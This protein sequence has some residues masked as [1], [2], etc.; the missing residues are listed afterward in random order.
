MTQFFSKLPQTFDLQSIGAEISTKHSNEWA[1]SNYKH[2]IYK[3][4]ELRYQQNVEMT[5]KNASRAGRSRSRSSLWLHLAQAPSP[6]WPHL[7]VPSPQPYIRGSG[8]RE[9]ETLVDGEGVSDPVSGVQHKA[10]GSSRS[11]QGQSDLCEG[12]GWCDG[13]TPLH[14]GSAM[15]FRVRTALADHS[16]GLVRQLTALAAC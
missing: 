10:F 8:I 11:T 9:S 6:P 2:S 1:R 7:P 12:W 13:C 4:S 5:F 14:E 3:A 16:F 15:P